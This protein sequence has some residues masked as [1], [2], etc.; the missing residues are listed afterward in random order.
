MA[1]KKDQTQ[2]QPEPDAVGEAVRAVDVSG[3]ERDDF[4]IANRYSPEREAAMR[5]YRES[6]A[7]N[8]PGRMAATRSV[9]APVE[10]FQPHTGGETTVFDPAE[11]TIAEVE[12]FADENPGLVQALL[13]VE[14]AQDEPRV[15]LVEKLE[16]RLAQGQASADDG[17]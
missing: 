16:H 1:T 17:G 8:S 13:E 4:I 2:D 11:H 3:D 12:V 9:F 15:T 5:A 7:Q 10:V 6:F 14:Q